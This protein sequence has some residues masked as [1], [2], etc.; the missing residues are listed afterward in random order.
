MSDRNEIILSGYTSA[1]VVAYQTVFKEKKQITN[2]LQLP[3][4]T[5]THYGIVNA[6]GLFYDID[7]IEPHREMEHQFH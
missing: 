3:K 6:I 5:V 7:I 4:L 1:K 2:S